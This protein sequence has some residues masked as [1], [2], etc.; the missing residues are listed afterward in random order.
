V[1]PLRRIN[2]IGMPRLMVVEELPG[3]PIDGS[4]RAIA[5]DLE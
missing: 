1:T 2:P 4:A 5:G 3:A